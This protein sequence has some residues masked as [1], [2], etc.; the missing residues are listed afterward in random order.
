MFVL[1]RPEQVDEKVTESL[2]SLESVAMMLAEVETSKFHDSVPSGVRTQV[3][4]II[5]CLRSIN[6]ST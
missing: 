1:N 5:R 6:S 4:S 2:R 3:I